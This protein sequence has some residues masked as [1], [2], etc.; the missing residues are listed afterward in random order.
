MDEIQATGSSIFPALQ[1]VCLLMVMGD[2]AI[3]PS[4][5]LLCTPAVAAHR[6]HMTA[7]DT[8]REK[9]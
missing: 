6:P 7:L 8:I 3:A 5:P 1:D 9:K 4:L 2:S